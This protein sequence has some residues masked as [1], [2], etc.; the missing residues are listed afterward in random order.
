[1][2]VSLLGVGLLALS[3]TIGFSQTAPAL[4]PAPAPAFAP[5]H[6]STINQRRDFQQHRIAQGVR[7]GQLTA[8]ETRHLEGREMRIGRTERHMR[9]ANHGRLTRADRISLNHRL[10]RTSRAIYRDKH[11]AARR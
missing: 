6:A 7:S 10:N 11:N 4:A 3:S 1:M 9:Y 8:R 5:R 2:K